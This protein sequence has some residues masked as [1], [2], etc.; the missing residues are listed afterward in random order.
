MITKFKIFENS[1]LNDL[2]KHMKDMYN[3]CDYYLSD[4]LSNYEFVL[5]KEGVVNHGRCYYTIFQ[6][7]IEKFSIYITF[8]EQIQISTL[9][10]REV[11]LVDYDDNK[12]LDEQLEKD[13]T[14]TQIALDHG[15]KI[16]RIRG[17]NGVDCIEFGSIDEQFGDLI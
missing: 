4:K 1:I 2:E 11:L 7:N 16:I 8:G 17:R 13:E 3:I 10:Y 14:E 15:Y 5:S 6:N 12:D 9:S